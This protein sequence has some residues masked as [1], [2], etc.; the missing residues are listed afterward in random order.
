MPISPAVRQKRSSHFTRCLG[1]II[2]RLAVTADKAGTFCTLDGG[3]DTLA[4]GTRGEK[5]LLMLW[6]KIFLC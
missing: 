3:E 6:K 2:I 5:E 1:V 4:I